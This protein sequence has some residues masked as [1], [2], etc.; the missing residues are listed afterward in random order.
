MENLASILIGIALIAAGIL[1]YWLFKPKDKK[2]IDSNTPIEVDEKKA[3]VTEAIVTKPKRVYKKKVAKE[4]EIS[5]EGESLP[6][7]TEG[8]QQS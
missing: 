4:E 5:G 6:S 1:S 2:S 3:E 8:G 7:T